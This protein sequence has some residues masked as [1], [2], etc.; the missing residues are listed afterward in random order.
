MDLLR[1]KE[2]VAVARVIDGDHIAVGP[3]DEVL[4]GPPFV[5]V[6]GDVV[7]LARAIAHVATHAGPRGI[8]ASPEHHRSDRDALCGDTRGGDPANLTGT[9]RHDEK[10]RRGR[11]GDRIGNLAG[12]LDDRV[13]ETGVDDVAARQVQGPRA[14]VEYDRVRADRAECQAPLGRRGRECPG[15]RCR[16]GV[17]HARDRGLPTV[18]GHGVDGPV[19]TDH[20]LCAGQAV[21][22]G[23]RGL[24]SEAAERGHVQAP[25]LAGRR[26]THRDERAALDDLDPGDAHRSACSHRGHVDRQDRRPLCVVDEDILGSLRDVES[27]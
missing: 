5:D 7:G 23:G 13:G 4:G 20:R 16:P 22:K 9:Q 15:P 3:E 12:A 1:R 14:T 25:D 19:R 21:G 8:P 26:V 11:Q 24:G 10:F 27:R 17:T 2:D 18:L 6:L